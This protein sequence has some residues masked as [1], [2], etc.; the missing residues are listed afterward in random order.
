M[1]NAQAPW[2]YSGGTSQSSLALHWPTLSAVPNCKGRLVGVSGAQI[3][4]HK[5]LAPRAPMSSLPSIAILTP[6]LVQPPTQLG[7]FVDFWGLPKQ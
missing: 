4:V 2:Q 6:D 5:W 7:K 3:P 1:L